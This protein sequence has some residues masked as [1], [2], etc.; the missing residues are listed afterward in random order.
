L[1]GFF[2]LFGLSQ[3]TTNNASYVR[4]VAFTSRK[5]PALNNQLLGPSVQ[6]ALTYVTL[7][8]E[9]TFCQKT[10]IWAVH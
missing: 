4:E 9:H 6:M 3:I 2:I 7:F 5:A 8:G 1:T 10:V